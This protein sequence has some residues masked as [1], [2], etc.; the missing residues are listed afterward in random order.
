M[1]L[2][3]F[4]QMAIQNEGYVKCIFG[5]LSLREDDLKQDVK[6]RKAYVTTSV[7]II[8]GLLG[9][10]W[11]PGKG[12]LL[13][14]LPLLRERVISLFS[15][16]AT[17][18]NSSK[19]FCLDPYSISMAGGGFLVSFSKQGVLA[20]A[21]LLLPPSASD[22]TCP[23]LLLITQCSF[24]IQTIREETLCL[25]CWTSNRCFLNSGETSSSKL[26]R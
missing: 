13:A 23:E 3:K 16:S 25:N 14:H 9:V 4:N 26:S 2:I 10:C 6:F 11:E 7:S 18:W 15:N 12:A 17:P 1:S 21:Q 20:H 5:S 8:L 24:H 22:L 19:L